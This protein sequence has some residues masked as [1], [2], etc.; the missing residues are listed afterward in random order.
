MEFS[1]VEFFGYMVDV[2]ISLDCMRSLLSLFRELQTLSL[3]DFV[4]EIDGTVSA[5]FPPSLTSISIGL[6]PAGLRTFLGASFPALSRLELCFPSAINKLE[7][8]SVILSCFGVFHHWFV[9]ILRVTV[10]LPICSGF[11]IRVRLLVPAASLLTVLCSH[12]WMFA[13]FLLTPFCC[14][15]RNWR[16]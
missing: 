16:T 14:C 8:L 4:C 9:Q 10:A 5:L 1:G 2:S 11:A 3:P 15:L 6:S 7:G 12:R 13:L